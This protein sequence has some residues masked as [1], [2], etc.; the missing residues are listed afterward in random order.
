MNELLLSAFQKF[1]SAL[2]NLEQFSKGNNFFDNISCLDVFFSE[3]RNITFMLQKSLSHTGNMDIYEKNRDLYLVNDMGKWFIEKRNKTTKEYPFNLEKK[4]IITAYSPQT[5]IKFPTQVFTIENDIEYSTLLNSFEYYFKKINTVEVYFSVEFSFFEKG[6]EKDLYEDIILGIKNMITFLSA[7][8]KD[9]NENSQ[10]CNR[11]E[12]EIKQ[13]KFYRV[14][15]EFLFIDD[16]AYYCKNNVFERGSRVIISIENDKKR[17]T[18][19]GFNK[20]MPNIYGGDNLFLRFTYLHC[21]IYDMQSNKIMPTFML[22]FNDDTF[23]FLTFEASIRTTCYRYVN[24]IANRVKN[25]NIKAVFYVSE[26]IRY[27]SDNQTELDKL[28]KMSYPERIHHKNI[29]ELSFYMID[30]NLS[31]KHFHFMSD[32]V[33][34]PQY[35]LSTISS[36]VKEKSAILFLNP[37]YESFKNRNNNE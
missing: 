22:I 16:Y 37:I 7:M 13:F 28:M 27:V 20:L 36:Q 5:S 11:L 6:K 18:L 23:E 4:I 26:T 14:P 34:N 15:K 8:K 32:K 10:L 2:K 25:E 31:K 30:E 9:L 21:I 3:Y 33:N 12:K 1:Y 24:L 17:A 35:L 19:S 29:D